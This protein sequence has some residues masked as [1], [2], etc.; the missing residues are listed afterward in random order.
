MKYDR[1]DHEQAF[2]LDER[3]RWAEEPDMY[4][5]AWCEETI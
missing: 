4:R 5:P 3:R 2:H 1:K